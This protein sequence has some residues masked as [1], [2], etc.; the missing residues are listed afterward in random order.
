MALKGGVLVARSTET[1]RTTAELKRLRGLFAGLPENEREFVEPL[2]QNAAF[3][4]V[5]LEDLS[6]EISAEG[7][8]DEYQNGANQF[9]R[10]A[11]AALQAYN[12]TAKTYH[13]LMVKLRERLPKEQQR[14]SALA[15][16]MA[17]E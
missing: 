11:S 3:L 8:T 14:E 5:T 12:Q 2:L 7:A 15:A 16:M 4:C 1:N 9:G 17:D 6:K 10:K 13:N